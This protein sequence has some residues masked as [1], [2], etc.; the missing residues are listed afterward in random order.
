MISFLLVI[1]VKVSGFPNILK[2]LDKKLHKKKRKS[3][4]QGEYFKRK[5]SVNP[6]WINLSKF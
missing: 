1:H 2:T 5:G 4:P 6:K 3:T